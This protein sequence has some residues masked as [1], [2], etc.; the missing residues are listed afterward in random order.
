MI[1]NLAEKELR[2][3]L[4]ASGESIPDPKGKPMKTPTL[5]RLF[6][7]FFRVSIIVSQEEEKRTLRVM[8]LNDTHR[9]VLALFGKDFEQYYESV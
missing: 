7:L 8:N 1:Y 9:R 5:K 3:K 2:E 6:H 4:A